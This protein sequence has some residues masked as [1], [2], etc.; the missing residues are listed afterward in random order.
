LFALVS[1]F[2]TNKFLEYV[3]EQT[4]PYASQ[5]WHHALSQNIHNFRHGLQLTVPEL[6]KMGVDVW[7]W[8][9]K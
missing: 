5:V 4:N 1:L 7:N 6:K 2:I 3:S 8:D 9:S